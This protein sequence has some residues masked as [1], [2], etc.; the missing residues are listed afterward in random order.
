R[1]S[2]LDGGGEIDGGG[3][4]TGGVAGLNIAGGLLGKDAGQAGSRQAGNRKLGVGNEAVN[5]C[6]AGKDIHG[7]GIGANGGGV[8][9]RNALLNGVVIEQVTGLKVIGGVEDK[10]DW[11]ERNG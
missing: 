1:L 8:D 11:L 7:R 6:S 3:E 2:R 4:D 10:V 9:P 5:L